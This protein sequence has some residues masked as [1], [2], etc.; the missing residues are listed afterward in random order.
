MPAGAVSM[1][2]VI[3]LS[4]LS[5]LTWPSASTSMITLSPSCARALA[6][7]QLEARSCRP[8]AARPLCAPP[9]RHQ[10]SLAVDSAVG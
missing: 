3:F 7:R 2:E 1:A 5:T 6:A 9:Q 8:P 10:Q 4:P